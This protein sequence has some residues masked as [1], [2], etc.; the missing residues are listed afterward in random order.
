ML[1]TLRLL[2]EISST[3]NHINSLIFVI[4]R[5]DG[6][7]S[8]RDLKQNLVKEAFL[9]IHADFEQEESTI[10][11]ALEQKTSFLDNRLSDLKV[12]LKKH[13]KTEWGK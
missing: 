3:L 5:V 11:N 7:I 12:S 13:V 2:L 10:I 6:P 1:Q 4:E 8:I 9:I